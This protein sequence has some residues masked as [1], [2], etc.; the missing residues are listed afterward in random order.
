MTWEKEKQYAEKRAAELKEKMIDATKACDKVAFEKAYSKSFRYM[1]SKE[2]G[3]MMTMFLSH[4]N[5]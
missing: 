1:T 5:N 4:M 2:R 3:Q